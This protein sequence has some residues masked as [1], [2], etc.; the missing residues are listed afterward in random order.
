[1]NWKE[2]KER[3]VLEADVSQK[4]DKWFRLSKFLEEYTELECSNTYTQIK[5]ELEDALFTLALCSPFCEEF[6]YTEEV[7]MMEYKHE[8]M[9]LIKSVNKR[10]DKEYQFCYNYFYNKLLFMDG[11]EERLS[12]AYER[13]ICGSFIGA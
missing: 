11:I 6:V 3:T 4:D 10:S 12:S 7:E 8:V 1:M 2:F 5:S 9:E 13:I